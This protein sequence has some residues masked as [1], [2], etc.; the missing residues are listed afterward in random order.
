MPI[1]KR[2]APNGSTIYSDE[3]KACDGLVNAGYKKHYRVTHCDAAFTNRRAHVNG[4]EN[5]RGV[6][7]TDSPKCV[8]LPVKTS[9][10][11]VDKRF[12]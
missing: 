8:V 10:K 1:I 9:K 4:I 5:F 3:G 12:W 11:G 7:K 6:A 2:L